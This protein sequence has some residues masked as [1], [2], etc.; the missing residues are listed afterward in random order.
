MAIDKLA[1]RKDSSGQ[2]DFEL[3]A[4][5]EEG[6]TDQQMRDKEW[7]QEEQ[8]INNPEEEPLALY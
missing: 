3:R 6:K 4:E 8:W 7:A 2:M 1:N 5:E